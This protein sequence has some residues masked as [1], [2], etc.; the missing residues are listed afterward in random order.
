MAPFF[1]REAMLIENGKLNITEFKAIFNDIAWTRL[2]RKLGPN[3]TEYF[4]VGSLENESLK[5]QVTIRPSLVMAISETF[6]NRVMTDG[7]IPLEGYR[8]P[9]VDWGSSLE[10]RVDQK[11]LDEV[12]AKAS[13]KSEHASSTLTSLEW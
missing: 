6:K 2:P 7:S 5:I 12:A 9:L 8:G 13:V 10:M 3:H 11:F 1:I 4:Y